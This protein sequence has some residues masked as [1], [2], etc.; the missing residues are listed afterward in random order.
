VRRVLALAGARSLA[1]AHTVHGEVHAI[2]A[3]DF[4]VIANEADE[5]LLTA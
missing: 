1:H 5:L 4:L 2:E 3:S